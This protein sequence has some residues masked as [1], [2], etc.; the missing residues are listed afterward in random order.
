MD[1]TS[2]HAKGLW[3][4]PSDGC[5]AAVTNHRVAAVTNHRVA[6]V[7][8]PHLRRSTANGQVLG[9]DRAESLHGHLTALAGVCRGTEPWP[10]PQL[11]AR[12]RA[13]HVH[14]RWQDRPGPFAALGVRR[15][16]GARDDQRCAMGV[17]E[18]AR[19]RVDRRR[20]SR[21]SPTRCEPRITWL[22]FSRRPSPSR[23]C[24]RVGHYRSGQP[25][26]I[27]PPSGGRA[28]KT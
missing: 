11:Q 21:Y 24:D 8:R 3:S 16:D 22:A 17:D 1:R 20:R 19:E 26:R 18:A 23:L 14:D 2:V 9:F 10:A 4:S 7:A 25:S 15:R 27:L 6:A 12:C 5:S 28:R 13:T